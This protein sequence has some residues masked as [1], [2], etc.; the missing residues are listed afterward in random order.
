VLEDGLGRRG[1]EDEGHDAAG[2]PA[3]R[4]GED[5]GAERPP[6][7]LGPGD[8]VTGG[9]LGSVDDRSNGGASPAR[10]VAA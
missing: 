2:A 10:R 9:R 4:A 8:G 5:V 1:M 3:V 6:E 7:E